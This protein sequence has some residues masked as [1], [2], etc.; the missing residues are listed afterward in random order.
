[1]KDYKIAIIF[2]VVALCIY[3]GFSNKPFEQFNYF[4][5]L[6]ESL[7]HGR[8]DI[9]SKPQ[10]NELVEVAG[11]YYVVYPPAP[12][13]VALPFVAIFGENINQAIISIL[14][15]S[16]A[17][18]LF[19]ILARDY[20]KENWLAIT[21]TVVFGFGTNFFLTALV[22]SS[23]YFAHICAVTF[24]ICSLIF[25]NRNRPVPTGIF[26]ALAF[27]SRLPVILAIFSLIWI[28]ISKN[29]QP[30]KK[31]ILFAL[32]VVC[33]IIIYALYN[34]ARFGSFA[35]SGYSLIPGV[36]SEPWF[37]EGIFSPSYIP[38]QLQLIFLGMPK[39]TPS[40][41]YFLPSNVG[42]AMWLTTPFLIL[43]FLPR[44][45]KHYFVFIISV[46]LIAIPSLLHGTVGFTQF[47]Y[48]FSLDYIVFLLL[49]IGFVLAKSK[50]N[51][52]FVY[53]LAGLSVSINFYVVILYSL[54]IFKV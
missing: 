10:L 12:A 4:T 23:W 41:P 49:A 44:R 1:M 25:A 31:L 37:K 22:G 3:F 38:R 15:A 8:L 43:V 26:F 34:L 47:G 53:I 54:G 28:L 14:M 50:I 16:I 2:S 33:G 6:A 21:L 13:I 32:P 5:P 51:K 11:K 17:V 18:G 48:R 45:E 9:A 24:L 7:L 42:M 36:L 40:F 30:V 46:L 39:L 19:Y 29:K 27:L 52:N 35:Q 20:F